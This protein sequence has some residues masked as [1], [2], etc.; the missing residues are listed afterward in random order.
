[1]FSSTH[2]SPFMRDEQCVDLHRRLQGLNKDP[3][4]IWRSLFSCAEQRMVAGVPLHVLRRDALLMHVA[5]HAAHHGDDPRSKALEDLRRALVA[6]SD[7]EWQRALDLAQAYDG[8]AVFVCGLRLVMEGR[9]LASR[10]KLNGTRSIRYELR[11]EGDQIAEELGGLLWSRRSVREKIVTL[12]HELFPDGDYM[13][14]WCSIARRGQPGLI[15]AY[16]WRA[17]WAMSRVPH[18][19]RVVWRV[20]RRLKYPPGR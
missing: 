3:E 20:S 14:H 9:M 16:I 7:E 12:A 18:A 8:V 17:I 19:T 15:A 10:L 5:L 1:M 6:A 2:A 13:R 11:Q 4:I